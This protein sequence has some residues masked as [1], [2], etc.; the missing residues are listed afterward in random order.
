MRS[1]R[2]ALGPGV[3]IWMRWETT[4]VNAPEFLNG[5]K[6]DYFFE[7]IIPIVALEVERDVSLVK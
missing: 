6:S 7:Q 5:V 3:E 2:C 4:H 1:D